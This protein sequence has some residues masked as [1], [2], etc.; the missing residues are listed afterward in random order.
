M[1]GVACAFQIVFVVRAA[2]VLRL[3]MVNG[4]G[5]LDDAPTKAGLA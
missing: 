2:Q 5:G 1:A 3:L 4:V